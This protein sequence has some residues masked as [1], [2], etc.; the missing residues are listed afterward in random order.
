MVVSLMWILLLLLLLMVLNGGGFLKMLM[1]L[2]LLLSM[3]ADV[4]RGFVD[5]D[6]VVAVVVNGGEWW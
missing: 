4:G 1:L 2:L 5:V 6:V 3:V